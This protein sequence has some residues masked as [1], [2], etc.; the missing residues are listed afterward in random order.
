MDARAVFDGISIVGALGDDER[1]A[2]YRLTRRK[3]LAT[4]ELLCRKGEQG[5]TLYAV[6]SGRLKVLATGA[7]G[8]EYVFNVMQPGDTIGEIALMDTGTRSASVEALEPCEL[9]A[10]HRRDLLP[11]LEK[12]PKAAIEMAS[13]LAR[14]VRRLSEQAA[15]TSFLPLSTRM[16]K[17]LHALASSDEGPTDAAT[18][19][20]LSQQELADML[21][22]T[23][24]SVNKWLRTWEGEGIIE[25]SRSRVRVLDR[26]A[27]EA[28]GRSTSL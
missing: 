16:A 15:D 11:F 23:R 19:V 28:I 13:V 8:R 10:L 6:V 1:A 21:G 26:D 3:Q 25:L 22:A 24:E 27:L 20:R 4:R 12:N 7:S 5:D 18:E 17:K 14:L 9:L 2:L